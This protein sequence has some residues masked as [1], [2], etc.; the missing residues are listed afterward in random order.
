MPGERASEAFVVPRFLRRPVRMLSRLDELEARMPRFAVTGITFVLLVSASAYGAYLGGHMPAVMQAVSARTGFAVA[1]IRIS[2]DDQTSELDVLA[3]LQLDGWTA[4]VGFNADAARERLMELPW[5]EGATVR[6]IYPDAI[7]VALIERKPFALWQ[8]GHE[9]TIIEGD[10]RPIAPFA[11]RTGRELP[12][13]IGTGAPQKAAQFVKEMAAY[14][15]LV[16]RVKAYVRIADRRWDLHLASGVQI[17]LPETDVDAAIKEL[18]D[19]DATQGL[20]SRDIAAVDMRLAERVIVELTPGAVERR[21][22]QLEAEKKAAKRAG[23][24]I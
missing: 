21:T 18:L 7:E 11:G 22:A 5:V 15:Q 10:G 24:S 6:K 17:K 23:R 12:L 14:P 20:L 9:L 1:D 19:L 8:Q 2:G 4:L 3:Q 16:D 13:V